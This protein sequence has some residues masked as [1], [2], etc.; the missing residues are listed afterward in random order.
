MHVP[1]YL[2]WVPM[3]LLIVALGV[4]PHLLFRVTDDAVKGVTADISAEPAETIT[5]AGR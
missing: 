2:A 5:A 1:E 4:Y 3:L